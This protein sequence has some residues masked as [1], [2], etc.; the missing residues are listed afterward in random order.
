MFWQ[1]HWQKNKREPHDH[2]CKKCSLKF[3][4]KFELIHHIDNIHS[5][6][7]A[8]NVDTNLTEESEDDENKHGVVSME[9]DE[10]EVDKAEASVGREETEGSKQIAPLEKPISKHGSIEEDVP[11][12]RS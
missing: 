8:R 12:S 4:D 7:E 2:T 5:M 9:S 11:T 6:N 10:D 3:V 1:D